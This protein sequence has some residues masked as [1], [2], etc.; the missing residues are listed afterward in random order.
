MQLLPYLN[1]GKLRALYYNTFP[2]LSVEQLLSQLSISQIQPDPIQ[3]EY[4]DDSLENL[5][6]DEAEQSYNRILDAIT[7]SCINEMPNETES[8]CRVLQI[9]EIRNG[10]SSVEEA[11]HKIF[12]TKD[13]SLVNLVYNNVTFQVYPGPKITNGT[14]NEADVRVGEDESDINNVLQQEHE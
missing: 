6:L 3:F 12:D 13:L 14:S 10:L 1:P 7:N 5:I 9:P 8:P 2:T 11:N 4:N